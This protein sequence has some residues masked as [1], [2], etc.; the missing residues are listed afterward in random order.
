M[1]SDWFIYKHVEGVPLNK[2]FTTPSFLAKPEMNGS[3][4]AQIDLFY[5]LEKFGLLYHFLCQRGKPSGVWGWKNCIKVARLGYQ[6]NTLGYNAELF[7]LVRIINRLAGLNRAVK[8]TKEITKYVSRWM[9]FFFYLLI[10]RDQK[11]W[12]FQ[13]IRFWKTITM[14]LAYMLHDKWIEIHL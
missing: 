12:K 11:Y 4:H 6:V 9:F 7:F 2:K 14:S 1:V 13:K 8:T 3:L 10:A 5:C